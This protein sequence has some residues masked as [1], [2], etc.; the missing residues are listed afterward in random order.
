[1]VSATCQFL[2]MRAV[3]I[4]LSGAMLFAIRCGAQGSPS[5]DG[6]PIFPPDNI[7]NT[8]VDTLP[9]D[10]LSDVYIATIGGDIGLHP[11][12]GSGLWDGGPIGIPFNVVPGTQ[13]KVPVTFDYADESDPGPYPI[14]PNPAFEW[15]SDHHVL[16]LD[17]DNAILYELYAAQRLPDGSVHAGSGAT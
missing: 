12:F 10:P 1:M 9:L 14:P 3:L 16:I 5:I 15:G 4:F 11:D 13:A 17:R 6:C 7:W 2:G 8:P